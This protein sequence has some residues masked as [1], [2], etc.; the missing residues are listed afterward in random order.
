MSNNHPPANSHVTGVVPV[1]TLLNLLYAWSTQPNITAMNEALDEPGLS[2][3][4]CVP[5]GVLNAVRVFGAP[6]IVTSSSGLLDE[7]GQRIV[8]AAHDF[9]MEKFS[10]LLERLELPGPSD[11][12]PY[13]PYDVLHIAGAGILP[14]WIGDVGELRQLCL[15]KLFLVSAL[16]TGL[17]LQLRRGLAMGSKGVGADANMAQVRQNLVAADDIIGKS[18]ALIGEG[19]TEVEPE[20]G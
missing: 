16:A 6:N 15:L 17:Q 7:S 11:P 4:D 18:L 14:I 1:D 19:A 12:S 13:E 10:K 20:P 3:E 5:G 8:G 2:P 9:V